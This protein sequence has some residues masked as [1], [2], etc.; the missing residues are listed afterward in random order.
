[1]TMTLERSLEQTYGLI[2]AQI[3]KTQQIDSF[4]VVRQVEQYRQWWKPAKAS[5]FLLGESHV[6]T[7]DEDFNLKCSKYLENLPKDYPTNYVRAVYCFGNGEPNML[8][9][10]LDGKHGMFQ[11][12]EI[13]CS[14]IAKD[15]NV[16][17]EFNE[18]LKTGEKDISQRLRNK[19]DVL[20]EMQNRGIWLMDAS[21]IGLQKPPNSKKYNKEER[22][23]IL[24][25]ELNKSIMS[26]K[27]IEKIIITSWDGYIKKQI[28]DARPKHIIVIGAGVEK[29]LG[30]RLK[31]LD[32]EL[33]IEKHSVLFQP[34]GLRTEDKIEKTHREYQRI[35]SK[36]APTQYSNGHAF[37]LEHLQTKIQT[38]TKKLE[39]KPN[40]L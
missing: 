32:A 19:V 38:D 37:P 12:W 21:I 35:C 6:A 27:V 14:C 4:D 31:R 11:F 23:K 7:K 10:K 9:R 1:M 22:Q 36:Y 3:P 2:K 16:K 25:Q 5:V 39:Q 28:V 34:Q 30:E 8:N 15:S 24:R 33:G 29:I 40:N 18:I 26:P 13:F 20:T 17:K